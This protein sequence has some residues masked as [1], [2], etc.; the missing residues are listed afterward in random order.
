M[1]KNRRLSRAIA[2]VGWGGLLTKVD[3]KLKLKR[4][5]GQLARID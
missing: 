3:C 1:M 2:D 4:K 5:G